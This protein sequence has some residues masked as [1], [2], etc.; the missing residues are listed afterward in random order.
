MRLIFR[1]VLRELAPPF[2]LGLAAYTFVLLIRTVLF[3]A[4]FPVRRSASFV[5]VA[6]LALLSLPWMVVLTIPMAFLLAVLVGLGRLGVDSELI[7]LRSCGGGPAALY[8]P[9]LAGA[10]GL[11][12]VVL[13]LYNVVLPPAN[14]A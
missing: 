10:A 14:E 11:S 12:L 13:L 7:A 2:L 1:S 8:R 5:D 6:R 3:L 9:E 4:D